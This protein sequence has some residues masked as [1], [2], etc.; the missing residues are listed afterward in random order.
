MVH[1]SIAT[2]IR[3]RVRQTVRENRP[4]IDTPPSDRHPGEA[5]TA[6]YMERDRLPRQ[7]FWTAHGDAT[8]LP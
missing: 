7:A 2:R 4:G 1:D 3:A 6:I 8:R 5:G